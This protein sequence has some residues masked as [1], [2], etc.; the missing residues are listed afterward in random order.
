[1]AKQITDR[2]AKEGFALFWI[3]EK[4]LVCLEGYLR[5]E[6]SLKTLPKIIG[7][8]A[9]KATPIQNHMR[10]PQSVICQFANLPT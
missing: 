3:I 10:N 8:S 1:M 9:K 5:L 2:C 6:M 4:T 7:N